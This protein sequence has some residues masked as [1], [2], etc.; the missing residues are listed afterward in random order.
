MKKYSS[1]SK[2]QNRGWRHQNEFFH[3]TL[4]LHAFEYPI[5]IV[6]YICVDTGQIFQ[7]AAPG[8]KG[9]HS[10]QEIPL[11]FILTSHE[12]APAVSFARVASLFTPCAYL[13]RPQ[14][15]ACPFSERLRASNGRHNRHCHPLQDGTGTSCA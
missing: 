3:S 4:R 9:N 6:G 10:Q 14:L 2:L 1:V 11:E 12:R 13:A 5:Q 8:P 15:S 7:A